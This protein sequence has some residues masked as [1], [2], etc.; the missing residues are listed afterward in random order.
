MLSVPTIHSYSYRKNK[1]LIVFLNFFYALTPAYCVKIVFKISTYISI[2]IR[3]I[4]NSNKLYNII[5]QNDSSDVFN[6]HLKKVIFYYYFV[7]TLY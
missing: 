3:K 2:E 4:K 1:L 5:I 6:F 7:S